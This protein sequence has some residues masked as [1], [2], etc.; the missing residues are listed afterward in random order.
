MPGAR[1]GGWLPSWA[2]GYRSPRSRASTALCAA[3]WAESAETRFS[4]RVR[5]AVASLAVRVT[6][7]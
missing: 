2:T 4:P 5:A 7:A 3:M 6:R 1:L